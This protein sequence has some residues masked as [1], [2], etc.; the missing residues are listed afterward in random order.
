[1]M[2]NGD[3]KI[4]RLDST[5]NAAAQMKPGGDD[6]TATLVLGKIIIGLE[7]TALSS[8]MDGNNVV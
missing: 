6:V 2:T 4:M 8:S 7:T 1:M 3:T 5:E